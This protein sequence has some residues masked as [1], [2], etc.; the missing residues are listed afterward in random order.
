M[1]IIKNGKCS[2]GTWKRDWIGPSYPLSQSG[3]G[4]EIL[5]R[6]KGSNGF[7]RIE[8]GVVWGENLMYSSVEW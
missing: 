6:G 7:K 4:E 5:E 2:I 8:W 1:R 3:R